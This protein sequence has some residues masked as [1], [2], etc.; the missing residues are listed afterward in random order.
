MVVHLQ[1]VAVRKLLVTVA[2]LT[3]SRSVREVVAVAHHFGPA[4]HHLAWTEGATT[5]AAILLL[6]LELLE[7]VAKLL[8]LLLDL[9]WR[10]D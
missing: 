5:R 4:R 6:E 1:P 7:E 2:L 3:L 8:G 9:G 10:I